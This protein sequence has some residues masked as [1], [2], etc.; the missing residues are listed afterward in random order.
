M[1]QTLLSF[2]AFHQTQEGLHSIFHGKSPFNP[3]EIDLNSDVHNKL[4]DHGLVIGG[5]TG[6]QDFTEGLHGSGLTK[7]IPIAGPAMAK[8]TDYLFNDYIP[9][10]KMQMAQAAVEKNLK[11][12][13]KDGWEGKKLNEDQ[14]YR[15][16]AEQANA[17]FGELNYKML[18][19]NP[20]VQDAMRFV[21][22]AP[23]F[24]EARARFVGQA[25]KPYGQE[26][27]MALIRGAAGLYVGAR[28]LNKLLDDDY[29]FDTPFSVV[30][31]DK[32]YTL[33]SIPGDVYHLATDPRS[34]VNHRIS[35]IARG[36][37]EILTGK[38]EFG[39]KRDFDAQAIDFLKNVIPIPFQ[40]SAQ[41][42]MEKGFSEQTGIDSGLSAIGITSRKYRTPAERL[43]HQYMLDGLPANHESRGIGYMADKMRQGNFDGDEAS[44]LIHDGRLTT[45]DIVS[46]MNMAKGTPLAGD[47]EGL[48]LNQAI[49]VYAIASEQEKAQLHKGFVK[50]ILSMREM[51]RE[52]QE[53]AQKRLDKLK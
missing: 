31:G 33:R 10:L 28:I 1:K 11:R 49:E 22:L 25:L 32:E 13:G 4:L 14:I 12:Y 9:R 16:S 45:K 5:N 37:G 51:P 7:F 17:A 41:K 42:K 21:V 38:D 8:Y 36:V 23:D 29:H 6:I 43:A 53:E 35:P 19:R 2:S 50:K 20:S 39:R 15:L 47:F 46:A 26:Q 18:G 30:Y 40:A 44:Q 34:F 48:R 27:R 3:P 52:Q 24:L